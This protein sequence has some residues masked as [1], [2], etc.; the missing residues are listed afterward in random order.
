MVMIYRLLQFFVPAMFLIMVTG[1]SA[2]DAQ[3]TSPTVTPMAQRAPGLHRRAVPLSESRT[4]GLK[5]VDPAVYARA[6]GKDPQRIFEFVR[7]QVAYESY[8]GCL[9]GGR[10]TL[11]AMAGNSIDRS[12]LL[13]EMLQAAGQRVR[14]AQGILSE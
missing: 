3:A 4:L 12:V 9:R 6:L 11:L 14:Y 1:D 7:D 13:A 8:V 2:A 5:H 10:G